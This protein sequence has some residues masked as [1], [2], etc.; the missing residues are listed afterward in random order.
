MRFPIRLLK[1]VLP[2]FVLLSAAA[3]VAYLVET[4]PE[5]E[6]QTAEERTWPVSA[7]TVE[8]GDHRPD[9]R[10]Y[11][12]IVAGREV[13][14][15]SAVAGEIVEVAPG[16]RS[17]SIVQQGDLLLV[18]DPF[19]YQ[20]ALEEREAELAEA[21]A[22]LDELTARWLLETE[23]LARDRDI[24][25]V[26]SREMSR[27]ERLAATGA[28]STQ[29]L[30]DT[31]QELLR[32]RQ[33]VAI[34]ENTL[35][36]EAAR[37]EQQQ[38]IIARLEV[39]VRRA[40]RDVERT[41]I[42]APFA[43]FV[44]DIEVEQGQRV[45]VD[46]ALARLID[47]SRLEARFQLSEADYG[48][49]LSSDGA[50]VG[51]TATVSWRLG[52]TSL[53]VPAEIERVDATIQSD[54]GGISVFAQLS[55]IGTSTPLRPGAFVTVSLPGRPYRDV[56]RLPE[57]ALFATEEG[58]IVY[59]IDAEGRLVPRPVLV[60]AVAGDSVLVAGSLGNGDRVV[61]TR[62]TGIGSGVAVELR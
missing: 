3:A 1:A 11:G 59:V 8:L 36:A 62:F 45:R 19:D 2:L 14:V 37:I 56:A 40:E 35:A 49:L 30:D 21:R 55:D 38:A 33:Q 34:R 61:T 43:G 46:Q 15:V 24:L 20:T 5:A 4:R 53:E 58:D 18:I 50:L 28:V 23:A 60:A 7:V 39:R 13:D 48:H 9:L 29:A 47:P 42:S 27:R 31:R 52:G 41:R 16:F 25:E 44:T 54:T 51:E 32:Q 22:R 26:V 12:E 17:G 6:T 57:T 10:A